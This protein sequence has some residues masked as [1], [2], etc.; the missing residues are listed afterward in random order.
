M[1]CVLKFRVFSLL[2]ITSD[3]HEVFCYIHVTSL[4]LPLP[5]Q[6]PW[7]FRFCRSL[8]FHPNSLG[9]KLRS[10]AP[11]VPRWERSGGRSV[12]MPWLHYLPLCLLSPTLSLGTSMYKSYASNYFMNC[13]CYEE[14]FSRKDSSGWRFSS[15]ELWCLWLK[16]ICPSS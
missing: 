12:S 8:N 4:G 5:L 15:R 7:R 14:C 10:P 3:Q 1:P 2:A 9:M 16:S 6:C 13:Q 11:S